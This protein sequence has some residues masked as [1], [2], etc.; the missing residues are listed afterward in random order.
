MA[1]LSKIQLEVWGRGARNK[2]PNVFVG[3]V[4][5]ILTSAE[6]VINAFSV[7]DYAVYNF[8]ID[9]D[10]NVSFHVGRKFRWERGADDSGWLHQNRDISYFYDIGG[11]LHRM[12]SRTFGE[13][14]ITPQ[15]QL[16]SFISVSD[17]INFQGT[18][19]YMFMHN[20][21]LKDFYVPYANRLTARDFQNCII[22]YFYLPNVIELS[23]TFYN[24]AVKCRIY[25]ANYQGGG[26]NAVNMFN[27]IISGSVIYHH[28]IFLTSNDG[29]LAQA[30]VY[31]QSRGA[32][33]RAVINKSVPNP[34]T[35]VTVTD[36]TS[37]TAKINFTP[38]IAGVNAIDFYE[39]YLEN[40]DTLDIPRRYLP[41]SEI[42]ATGQTITGLKPDTNYKLRLCTVDEYYN[43][44]GQDTDEN[45]RAFSNEFFF[46]TTL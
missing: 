19:T 10:N 12:G 16:R 46:K 22:T 44:T 3:N 18:S 9:E 31:A 8:R 39:V 26:M 11:N 20:T 43:G 33:T 23:Q 45:R 2:A 35:N 13:E 14:E 15:K 17:T 42:T 38:A 6:D 1:A 36:I 29:G 25:I 28:P 7:P 27:N 21:L 34:A 4:G 37:T 41:F 24:N 40:I 30:L 32:I 5:H